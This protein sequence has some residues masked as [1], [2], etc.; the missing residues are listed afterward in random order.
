LLRNS[1][2]ALYHAKNISHAKAAGHAKNVSGRRYQFY[3]KAMNARA[4]ARA[5]LERE[6]RQ[7][8]KL[9]SKEPQFELV[10]Q[11]IL[12][13][14]DG[15]THAVEAL[16]RWQHPERGML[17]PQDFLHIAESTGL[18]RGLGDWV[19][20]QA[21]SQWLLWR[22]QGVPVGRVAVNV[23]REQFEG[24]HL[25]CSLRDIVQ[26]YAIPAGVLELELTEETLACH[27]LR[28]SEALEEIRRLGVSVSLDD[29]G[30]GYSSVQQM[31]RLP[32][33]NLKVSR[34]FME[35]LPANEDRC[36]VRAIVALAKNL[37][38]KVIAEGIE[39]PMQ[40]EFVQQLECDE[41]QGYL[42][43]RPVSARDMMGVANTLD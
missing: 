32:V 43:S 15:T 12:G 18:I 40:L 3:N 21:C 33:D 22:D 35:A 42:L 1:D 8:L 13:A 37:G 39:T 36:A 11:P 14:E 10:Y 7:A 38:F 9:Q 29:F 41:V 2:T 30:T 28:I 5:Q 31:K 27:R 26:A 24:G 23:S 6:F 19:L 17:L 20:R 25:L 34:S 16:V 4:E